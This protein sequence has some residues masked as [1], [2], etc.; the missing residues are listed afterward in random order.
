MNTSTGVLNGTYVGHERPE[1]G[2]GEAVDRP[3]TSPT[4]RLLSQ[5]SGRSAWSSAT[6][7]CLQTNGFLLKVRSET[8][9]PLGL[10]LGHS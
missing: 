6:S 5:Q 10:D 1:L 7:F 3:D 8:A 2:K 4:I 9:E